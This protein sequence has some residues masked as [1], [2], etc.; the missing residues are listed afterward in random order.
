MKRAFRAVLVVALLVSAVVGALFVNLAEANFMPPD[1]PPPIVTV[2][3]PENKVYTENSISVAFTVEMSPCGPNMIGDFTYTLD[4]ATRTLLN[5][6]VS[7]GPQVYSCKS[8]LSGLSEGTHSLGIAVSGSYYGVMLYGVH[9]YVDVSGGSDMVVFIVN[10][11]EPRVSVLSPKPSKTY[12]ATALSLDFTVSE[13]TASL[14]YSLDGGA[15]VAIVGNTTLY[16]FSGGTHTIVVEAEDLAG[17]VGSSAPVTFMVETAGTEQ[18]G[19]SQPAPFP[20]TLLIAAI[21]V[22]A[23]VSFGLVAYFLSRKRRSNATW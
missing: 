10:T 21:V 3:L 15:S 19:G 17:S 6:E 13:P 11:A 18:P 9:Y 12:N 2:Q 23:L 1:A 14:S 22:A 16:G 5:T 4:G 8:A 20:T 7:G